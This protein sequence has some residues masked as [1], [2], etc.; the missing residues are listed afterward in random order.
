M[1]CSGSTANIGTSSWCSW[2]YK[3]MLHTSAYTSWS[4]PGR[5]NSQQLYYPSSTLVSY[6]VAQLLENPQDLRWFRPGLRE[7]ALVGISWKPI[8]M[9]GSR[10]CGWW[11]LVVSHDVSDPMK[12]WQPKRVADHGNFSLSQYTRL[13][14]GVHPQL[15]EIQLKLPSEM[16]GIKCLLN[17]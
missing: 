7:M 16:S 4:W 10:L 1:I 17:H 12:N 11:M 9:G 3:L 6:H 14:W 8:A 2:E 13:A 15:R 5:Q